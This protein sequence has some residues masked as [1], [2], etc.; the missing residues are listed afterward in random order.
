MP[1]FDSQR[2]EGASQASPKSAAN[3]NPLSSIDTARAFYSA[4]L[5]HALPVLSEAPSDQTVST[6]TR[7][8][9]IWDKVLDG[10]SGI[11]VSL[12]SMRRAKSASQISLHSAQITQL[13]STEI[14]VLQRQLGHLDLRQSLGPQSAASIKFLWSQV[15]AECHAMSQG[16]HQIEALLS[17]RALHWQKSH[18]NAAL[19]REVPESLARGLL[20]QGR[21]VAIVTNFIP[22]ENYGF[23]VAYEHPESH[24]FFHGVTYHRPESKK[25]GIALVPAAYERTTTR[26]ELIIFSP[27]SPISERG[28]AARSWTRE[29][30][31]IEVANSKK[32]HRFD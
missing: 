5:L 21:Q 1:S 23:A 22:H 24:F 31:Y 16:R 6:L 30:F 29:D 20:K 32:L 26:G 14:P 3:S 28:P 8:L 11:G 9:Q 15:L 25:K 19:F 4:R 7:L 10:Y 12:Q 2:P 27:Q 13:L 18:S 17:A